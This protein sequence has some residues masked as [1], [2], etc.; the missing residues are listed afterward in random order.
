MARKINISH[1]TKKA[2]DEYFAALLSLESL[3][4]WILSLKKDLLNKENDYQFLINK[5]KIFIENGTI[6]FRY[7][8]YADTTILEVN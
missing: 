3:H 7:L 5:V 4:V 2:K 6:V 8:G 1:L